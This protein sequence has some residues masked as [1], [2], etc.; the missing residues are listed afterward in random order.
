MSTRRPVP[1]QVGLTATLV[2]PDGRRVPIL[3]NV[4]KT[5]IG[6]PSSVDLSD[7]APGPATL[8]LTLD[9]TTARAD[10]TPG[11]R[12]APREVQLPLT[13]AARRTI[14]P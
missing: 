12:L 10:G 5:A 13:V 14:P 11:T 2:T 8:E 3:Q 9:V 7:V 1:G 6:G 4:S